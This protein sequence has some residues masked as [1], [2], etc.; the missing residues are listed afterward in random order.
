MLTFLQFIL[1]AAKKPSAKNAADS[2]GKL[3]ELLVGR[4]L[5]SGKHVDHHRDEAG[6]SPKE[7]HDMHGAA[8][9]KDHPSGDFTKHEGYKRM[10][11]DAKTAAD[12]IRKHLKKHHG[13]TKISRV[14]WTSQPSYYEHE[15]KKKDP[16]SKA[17]LIVNRKVPI[18]LKVGKTKTP[19]YSNPGLGKFEEWAGSK[20]KK[21]TDEHAA[22]LAK[23]GNPSH[24]EYKE[25][26]EKDASAKSRKKS[27][28]IKA[29]SDRMN[30]GIASSIRKGMAK[31]SHK[32]LHELIK[33]S[34]APQ[35]KLPE[36]V[37]HTVH[38]TD[39]SSSHDVHGHDEHIHN[40]LSQF[41]SLHVDP[42]GTGKSVVIHGTHKKTGQK[43]KVWQT[44]VYA[45]GR[46]ANRNPRGAVTLPSESNK[47]VQG[48]H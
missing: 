39:G 24:E 31:K 1:E 3:H 26:T 13:I 18:S 33:H 37:S 17:D 5:N 16:N 30:S 4:E 10:V 21:H 9:F 47:D 41:H 8:L 38:N 12:G 25:G 45:G 46:P 48:D 22:T 44:N 20:L 36:V 6:L 42:R 7:A 15:T 40:Y 32:E 35:T 29:S 2:M 19:N 11:K 43:M 34:V 27:D 14:A 28:E 23:H